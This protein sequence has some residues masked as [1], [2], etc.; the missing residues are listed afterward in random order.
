LPDGSSTVLDIGHS[1]DLHSVSLT[2][3]E[4]AQNEKAF[5]ER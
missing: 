2:P 5:E 3:V 1:G 4:E